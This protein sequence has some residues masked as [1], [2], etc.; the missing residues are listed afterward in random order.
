MS[1]NNPKKRSSDSL[2]S[3]YQRRTRIRGGMCFSTAYSS[4]G[5][6][7][8]A[9]PTGVLGFNGLSVY[10]A[11][12]RAGEQFATSF[13]PPS[14]RPP[15]TVATFTASPTQAPVDSSDPPSVSVTASSALTSVLAIRTTQE[16]SVQATGSNKTAIETDE[17]HDSTDDGEAFVGGMVYEDTPEDA[18]EAFPLLGSGVSSVRRLTPDA[19]TS[20]RSSPLRQEG[21]S[22]SPKIATTEGQETSS[23]HAHGD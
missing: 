3:Y 4:A 8:V 23:R 5:R 22:T 20:Q 18:P 19:S 13:E 6:A 15:S 21:K 17:T 16:G 1:D 14:G 11:G 7:N 10:P 9:R 2:E 12:T